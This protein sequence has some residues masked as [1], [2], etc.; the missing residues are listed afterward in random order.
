LGIM[1]DLLA[2]LSG[3]LELVGEHLVTTREGMGSTQVRDVCVRCLD[4]QG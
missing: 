2:D 3:E 1:T 4:R